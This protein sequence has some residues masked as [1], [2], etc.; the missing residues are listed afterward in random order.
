MFRAF[1]DRC[2]LSADRMLLWGL[3]GAVSDK[4]SSWLLEIEQLLQSPPQLPDCGITGSIEKP[5]CK[6]M[7]EHGQRRK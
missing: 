2:S 5:V 7:L 4:V 6:G 1:W 3:P